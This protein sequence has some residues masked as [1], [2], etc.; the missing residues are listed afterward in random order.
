MRAYP[1]GSVVICRWSFTEQPLSVAQL[2]TFVA[3]GGL[4]SGVTTQDPAL[5]LF[6]WIDP[7][8]TKRTITGLGTTVNGVQIVLD[9]PGEYHA[10]LPASLEG[11]WSYRGYGQDGS[12]NPVASS[13]K[14]TFVIVPFSE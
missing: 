5:P 11:F 1:A 3:G 8:G 7:T 10:A 12:G 6:D 4:P 13:D 9:T 2:E 14:Q